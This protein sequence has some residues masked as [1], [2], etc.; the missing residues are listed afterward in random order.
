MQ[1]R[2]PTTIELQ[3]DEQTLEQARRLARLRHATLETLIK[4]I[5]ELLAVAEA[6]GDPVLGMFSQEPELIDRVIESAM[7]AREIDPLRLPSGQDTA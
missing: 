1:T 2:S 3:L 4:E 7:M 5:I 6:A